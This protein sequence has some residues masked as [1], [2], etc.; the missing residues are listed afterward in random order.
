M[1]LDGGDG[2]LDGVGAV[3]LRSNVDLARTRLLALEETLQ[4]T[5]SSGALPAG[6]ARELTAAIDL[7]QTGKDPEKI[8]LSLGIDAEWAELVGAAMRSKPT[9]RITLPTFR[10]R[11][12]KPKVESEALAPPRP[13][14]ALPVPRAVPA[15]S[16][17]LVWW[18][19]A[20]LVLLAAA[21]FMP[22]K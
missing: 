3:D 19:V 9:Q 21:I 13:A 14:P 20:A 1:G 4:A 8:L 17:G 10:V 2:L 11:I 7:L 22:L 18:L 6:M 15:P 5:R 12:P 16:S